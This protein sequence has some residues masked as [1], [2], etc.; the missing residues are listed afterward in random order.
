MPALAA[1]SVLSCGLFLLACAYQPPARA[2]AAAPAPTPASAPESAPLPE[3]LPLRMQGAH[4]V[5]EVRLEGRAAPL[6]MIVDTAAGRTIVDAALADALG[7]RDDGKVQVSG[8]A[9]ATDAVSTGKRIRLSLGEFTFDVRPLVHPV[10]QAVDVRFDLPAGTLS[11]APAGTQPG[12]S[13]GGTCLANV[14]GDGPA[15]FGFVDGTL[16]RGDTH[17]PIRAVVDTG[18]AQSVLNP[19]ALR[20]LGLG[21]DDPALRVRDA[22]TRGFGAGKIDTWLLGGLDLDIAGVATGPMEMRVSD[23]PVFGFIRLADRPG[24]ILGIDV[25]SRR[26]LTLLGG[27]RT[28]CI[29]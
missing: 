21:L 5:V 8:A 9:G 19:A 6:R 29:G 1:S 23:L 28:I 18:A 14:G 24:M 15:G 27:M 11:L 2:E 22:G 26:P 7:L 4:P 10:N 3:R 16:R 20:A 25:L 12:W 13:T 17:T